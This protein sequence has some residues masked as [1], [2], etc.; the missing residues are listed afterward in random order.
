MAVEG[1]K[2]GP[3]GLIPAVIQQ[4]DSRQVLMVGYMDA[5]ALERT[6]ASGRVWL[7]SRSRR[8]Y[9][10]KGDTSGNIQV[11]KSVAADCDG[12]ALLVQVDQTGP[13]CHTGA[14]S[15]FDARQ[16]PAGRLTDGIC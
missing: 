2:F 4:H 6:L 14:Q 1:L 7:W 12:D 10:R 8:E 15:C 16:L 9:W 11:V 3:D 13:A 5:T